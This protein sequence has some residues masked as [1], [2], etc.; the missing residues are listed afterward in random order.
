[1][2]SSLPTF[3]GLKAVASCAIGRA[4][5]VGRFFDHLTTNATPEESRKMFLRIREAITIA[6]PFLGMPACVPGCYGMIGVVERKG[7][8]YGETKVLRKMVI[9]EDDT[10]KGKEIRARIYSGVGNSEI[11]GLMDKYF[12]DLCK[13]LPQYQNSEFHYPDQFLCSPMLNNAYMGLHHCQSQR[14]S[15][16]GP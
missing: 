2:T 9:T 14:R 10:Q 12:T 11:F 5:I 1:M 13:I 16:R 3:G 8:E 15:F 4:D 6:F 7:K